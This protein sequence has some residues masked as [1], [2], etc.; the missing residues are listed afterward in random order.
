MYKDWNGFR[1][2]RTRETKISWF[3]L[4]VSPAIAILVFVRR[5][6]Y[7]RWEKRHD[8]QSVFVTCRHFGKE[9]GRSRRPRSFA[10]FSRGTTHVFLHSVVT[11]AIYW[12]GRVGVMEKARSH[13][14]EETIGF[15]THFFLSSEYIREC[16]S[17]REK[18]LDVSDFSWRAISFGHSRDCPGLDY[19]YSWRTPGIQEAPLT[20]QHPL[21]HAILGTVT[22]ILPWRGSS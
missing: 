18:F 10:M 17:K 8:G 15:G 16:G 12:R 9:N 20:M 13:E 6:R 11:P 2:I 7:A 3:Q 14:R 19:A 5:L 1:S 21:R 4:V 22:N